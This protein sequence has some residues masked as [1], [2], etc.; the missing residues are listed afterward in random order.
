MKQITVAT[1]NILHGAAVE[2]DWSRLAAVVRQCDADILGVQEVDMF[3]NRSGR[4]DSVKGLSEALD[5][6][7]TCFVPAMDYDG[8]QYGTAILSR[9]PLEI[10][11]IQELHSAGFEPRAMGVVKI[12]HPT[13]G[14]ILFANTHLSYEDQKMRLIQF[15]Q[16]AYRLFTGYPTDVPMILTGDFNTD[17]FEDFSALETIGF[18]LVNRGKTPYMTFRTEPM[19]IDNVVYRAS[20]LSP[21]EHGMIESDA[22]DHN[23]LWCRFE[24]I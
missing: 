18:A 13:C 6:P 16:L 11:Q 9:Y 5:M 21:T 2:Q 14:D 17:K 23:L 8:G 15:K 10:L 19:A 1:Y 22:S 3:T 12:L 7:Y 24:V 20:R 4:V